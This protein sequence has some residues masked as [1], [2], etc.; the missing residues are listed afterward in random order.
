MRFLYFFLFLLGS[1]PAIADDGT[2]LGA[3]ILAGLGGPSVSPSQSLSTVPPPS[4][5]TACGDVINDKGSV[6]ATSRSD[7]VSTNTNIS[8]LV[9]DDIVSAKLAYQCLTSV[10]FN[11]AVATRFLN[12]YNVTL[13]FQSTLAYLKTPTSGYKQPKV[14]LIA[15]I[16]KIQE[17]VNTPGAFPNQY[18]FEATLQRLVYM[19]HDG[20]LNLIAGILSAFNFGSPYALASVSKDGKE[21]PKVYLWGKSDRIRNFY[22]LD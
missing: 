17:Y 22:P 20:H 11:P 4:N 19:A 5:P 1:A 13:Q 21:L 8:L 9:I 6:T 10:P 15:G 16:N 18:A 3:Y 12:Y 2:G 7:F 14:D